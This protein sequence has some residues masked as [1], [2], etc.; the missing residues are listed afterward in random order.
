MNKIRIVGGVLLITALGFF[1][2][3][4]EPGRPAAE[5]VKDAMTKL[6]KVSSYQ[7]DM[8]IKG[9]L[10]PKTVAQTADPAAKKKAP[11]K[12]DFTIAGGIDKKD[13]LDPR[14]NFKFDGSANSDGQNGSAAIDMRLNKDALYFNLA[15]LMLDALPGGSGLSP[16]PKDFI[17]KYAGKWWK[18]AIPPELLKKF[19]DALANGGKADLSTED[20]KMQDLFYKTDFFK[21]LRF[22]GIDDVQAGKSYHYHG[23]LDKVAMTEFLSKTAEIQGKTI[24][25]TDR[26]DIESGFKNFDMNADLWVSKDS[27]VF[28]QFLAD[29]H[30]NGDSASADAFTG[31]IALKVTLAQFNQ[32]VAVEVP[33]DSTDFPIEQ[34]IAP[35]LGAGLG[36]DGTVPPAPLPS[37]TV[38]TLKMPPS[39]GGVPAPSGAA[40][41]K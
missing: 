31:T 6:S 27:G 39:A 40:K 33:A 30:L 24:S 12:F 16:I 11:V 7:F 38:P 21:D 10:A 20:K 35:L 29:I 18:I 19:S 14:L 32:P 1:A 8:N 2:C 28:N 25:P 9:D 26:Q 3:A 34:V 4:Q 5:V 17:D 41:V 36:L 13:P 15:K 22:V 37:G 23:V